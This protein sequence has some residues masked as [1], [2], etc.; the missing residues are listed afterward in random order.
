M[1]AQTRTQFATIN[2]SIPHL[3]VER[4]PLKRV[5]LSLFLLRSHGCR[6]SW[7]RLGVSR[8][9]KNA[10]GVLR[11]RAFCEPHV[12]TNRHYSARSSSRKKA[13]ASLSFAW[14]F[15]LMVAAEA[16]PA[17]NAV[18]KNRQTF[19]MRDTFYV[20]AP[21]KASPQKQGGL[22]LRR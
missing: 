3:S 18:A 17:S 14:K 12:A 7:G 4:Y 9:K 1:T 10:R 13:A 5:Y 6:E 8:Y 22:G 16:T 15:T 2:K 20:I 21:K 11:P 19:F